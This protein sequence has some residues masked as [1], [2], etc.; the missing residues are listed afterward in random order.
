MEKS[1]KIKIL[2][3][4]FYLTVLFVFLFYFFERFS[5]SELTSYKF[6]KENREY[7]EKAGGKK[8]KYIP[9][10]NDNSLHISMMVSLIKKHTH[11]WKI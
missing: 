11:G 3:G 10:L 9:C 7:F 8:Y 1:K 2:I 4:L 5:I 6:I